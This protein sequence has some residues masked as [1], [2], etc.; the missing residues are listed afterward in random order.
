MSN[1]ANYTEHEFT[2]KPLN[3]Y[4]H[5]HT[6]KIVLM[7]EDKREDIMFD[8]K[9]DTNVIFSRF[10]ALYYTLENDNADYSLSLINTDDNVRLCK[11]SRRDDVIMYAYNK[12]LLPVNIL[13]T[14]PQ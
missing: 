3:M 9:D 4:N 8:E 13:A 1:I 5:K 10:R 12:A 6:L 14:I 2:Y 11:A 7:T